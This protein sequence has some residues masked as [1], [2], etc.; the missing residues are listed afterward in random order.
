MDHNS[1]VPLPRLLAINDEAPVPRKIGVIGATGLVG[2]SLLPLLTESGW[3]VTACYRGKSAP[4]TEGIEW[5]SLPQPAESAELH[6]PPSKKAIEYWI[7]TAP[8]WVLPEYFAWLESQGIR[9]LVALSST[10]RFTKTDSSDPEEQTLSRRLAEAESSVQDWAESRGVEWVI[11]RPTLI[12]GFGRDKNIAEIARFTRRFGFFPLFGKAQGLRQPIHV[13]DVANACLAAIESP[14]AINHAYNISGGETLSYREMVSR[15]FTRM[16][17]SPLLLPV[18]LFAFRAACALL[19]ILPRYKN[20]S[21]A[22]AERMNRDMV[23]D[24]SEAER[25]LAFKPRAFEL[26]PEDVG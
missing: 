9:R 4:L 22:M 19:R 15:V 11:L 23:F 10:S 7:C 25:D 2:E 12:Y 26:F 14:A 24:H 17:R 5:L 6:P 16:D 18:P 21:V 20:W 1:L 13:Q 3:S 8:I